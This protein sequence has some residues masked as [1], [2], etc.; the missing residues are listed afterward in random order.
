VESLSDIFNPN[1][2]RTLNKFIN[3]RTVHLYIARL[4]TSN[5]H[6]KNLFDMVE[7]HQSDIKRSKLQDH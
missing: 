1:G 5:V 3:K 6:H 7:Y 2:N 4:A